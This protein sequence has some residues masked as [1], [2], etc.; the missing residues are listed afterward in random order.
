M[1]IFTNVKISSTIYDVNC[2]ACNQSK[3]CC[4]RVGV[5]LDTQD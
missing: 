4:N 3:K 2:Y 1:I 5:V